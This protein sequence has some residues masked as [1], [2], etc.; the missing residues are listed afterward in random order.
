MKHRTIGTCILVFLFVTVGQLATAVEDPIDRITVVTVSD[1]GSETPCR[2]TFAETPGGNP[3]IA[4]SSGRAITQLPGWPVAIGGDPNFAPT[5]GVLFEDLDGDGDLE[6][7]TS[8]TDYRIYALDHTGALMP[9]FPRVVIEMPQRAPSVGDLDGDG[10]MEI[11]QFT[12]GLTSGGRLYVI[13]HQGN[14]LPGFPKAINNNNISGIPA[15][16]DLDDD[17]MLEILVPERDWPLGYLHVFEA[18]GT[19]WGG[20]WPLALDHVPPR[21]RPRSGTWMP[22]ARTRSSTC[23]SPAS[24]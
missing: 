8:S 5:R 14:D 15:L 6:I 4:S 2:A 16:Y 22:T 7:I 13:D 9:G 10:D 17:G 19:E 1:A 21:A 3:V 18:D 12:R 24:T 23:P 11:V 20:N